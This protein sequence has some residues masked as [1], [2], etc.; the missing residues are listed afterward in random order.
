MVH[1]TQQKRDAVVEHAVPAEDVFT[2]SPVGRMF[3]S[4]DTQEF[5]SSKFM[6]SVIFREPSIE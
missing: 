5:R 3:V 4:F 6:E 2:H 1:T